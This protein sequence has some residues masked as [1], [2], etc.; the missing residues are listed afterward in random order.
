MRVEEGLMAEVR[1][2]LALGIVH[3]DLLDSGGHG[4]GEAVGFHLGH[5]EVHE[6][7]M[8]HDEHLAQDGIVFSGN[9][10]LRGGGSSGLSH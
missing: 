3:I 6:D 2:S 4:I 8:R 1:L 9:A 10:L 5:V 7:A